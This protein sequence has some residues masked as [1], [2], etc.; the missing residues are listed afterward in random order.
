MYFFFFG[1]LRT[2]LLISFTVFHTYQYILIFWISDL[3]LLFFFCCFWCVLISSFRFLELLCFSIWL[4]VLFFFKFIS[5]FPNCYWLLGNSWFGWYILGCCFYMGSNNVFTF[6]LWNMSFRSLLKIIRRV[7]YYRIITISYITID[8][9]E[10]VISWN[11]ASL[12][13]FYFYVD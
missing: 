3:E 6:I 12:F 1:R 7:S 13:F 10:P 2:H 9:W 5:F 8:K 4:V 11:F